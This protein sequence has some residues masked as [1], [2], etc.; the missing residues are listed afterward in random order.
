MSLCLTVIKY[1]FFFSLIMLLWQ[2][3]SLYGIILYGFCFILISVISEDE[4]Y[5]NMG[6]FILRVNY[7]DLP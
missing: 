5:L 1:N 6:R 4:L 2:E 3:F 7:I